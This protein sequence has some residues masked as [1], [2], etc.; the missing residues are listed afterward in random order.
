M[1]YLPV[2][3]PHFRHGGRHAGPVR[4]VPQAYPQAWPQAYSHLTPE[5]VQAHNRLWDTI[6]RHPNPEEAIN[7]CMELLTDNIEG[8]H[9]PWNEVEEEQNEYEGGQQGDH[10]VRRALGEQSPQGPPPPYQPR[11]RH[12]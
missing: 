12:A 11:R 3:N 6:L 5:L 1:Y 10:V 7:Q 9:R 4:L 2:M 8:G